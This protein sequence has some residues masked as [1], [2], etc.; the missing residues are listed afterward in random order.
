MTTAS[1]VIA[2]VATAVVGVA[3]GYYAAMALV[4]LSRQ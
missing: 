2:A 4:R 1:I 3:I